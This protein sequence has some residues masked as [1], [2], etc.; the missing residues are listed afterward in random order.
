MFQIHKLRQDW[1]LMPTALK[2]DVL[3]KELD[4]TRDKPLAELTRLD[5]AVVVRCKKL[6]W[7]PKN[8]NR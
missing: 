3:M 7:Y 8:I 2:L 4:E 6:L 5:V 1:E